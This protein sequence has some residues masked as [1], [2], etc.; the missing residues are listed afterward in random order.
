MKRCTLFFEHQGKILFN[1]SIYMRFF[2][3]STNI[4]LHSKN[5]N[6]TIKMK[7]IKM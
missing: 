6:L 5:I 4:I 3:Y 1:K 2:H 7:I